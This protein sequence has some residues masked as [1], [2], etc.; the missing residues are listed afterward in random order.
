[1]KIFAITCSFL[2]PILDLTFASPSTPDFK[3]NSYFKYKTK[4]IENALLETSEDVNQNT[5]YADGDLADIQGVFNVI[6]QVEVERIKLMKDKDASAQ[7]GLAALGVGL[8]VLSTIGKTLWDVG[9][10]FLKRKFC[11]RHTGSYE[12]KAHALIQELINEQEIQ[13]FG[14]DGKKAE[15]SDR[16]ALAQL[17]VLFHALKEVEAKTMQDSIA[18]DKDANAESWW[19]KAK[20]FITNKIGGI[21]R[22]FLC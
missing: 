17:K 7:V 3:D 19:K 14:D 10:H 1:M 8:N 22:K 11:P 4:R 6:A 20:R 21:T 18:N 16:E 5:D 12:F 15:E 9:K 13:A 2:L